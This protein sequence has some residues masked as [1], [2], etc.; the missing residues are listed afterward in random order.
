MPLA[1]TLIPLLLVTT[2][3]MP[4]GSRAEPSVGL[5]LPDRQA[6]HTQTSDFMARVASNQVEAAYQQLRPFLGVASEPFDQS[7]REAN[8][9][10]QMVTGQVGQPLASVHL[11]S[12]GI[13]EHFYRETWLQKFN[14]AAIA[15][16]LTF[17]RPHDDWKLVGVSYSTDLDALYQPQ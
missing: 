5:A 14:T 4:A 2:L 12:D 10:F 3:L 8:A 1:R 13:G 9:Y 16:T 15:W 7:A 17:Y 6:V 11:H